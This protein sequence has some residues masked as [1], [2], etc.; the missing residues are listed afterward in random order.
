MHVSATTEF[1][2]ILTAPSD[3]SRINRSANRVNCFSWNL[4]CMQRKVKRLFRKINFVSFRK[5][6]R[7]HIL[8]RKARLWNANGTAKSLL[9]LSSFTRME[10]FSKSHV[11]LDSREVAPTESKSRMSSTFHTSFRNELVGSLACCMNTRVFDE[12]DQKSDPREKDSEPEVLL[13]STWAQRIQMQKN[14]K[15]QRSGVL[16]AVVHRRTERKMTRSISFRGKALLRKLLKL[17][18]SS[19]PRKKT[20][21]KGHK[22]E[23]LQSNSPPKPVK[24]RPESP[25]RMTMTSEGDS[26]AS[27]SCCHQ[28]PLQSMSSMVKPVSERNS[29]SGSRVQSQSPSPSEVQQQICIE[30]ATM[31]TDGVFSHETMSEQ[32]I[33][34][35]IPTASLIQHSSDSYIRESQF[36][37]NLECP[38]SE[39]K[40]KSKCVNGNVEDSE[41]RLTAQSLKKTKASNQ[42]P[43]SKRKNPIMRCL[44]RKPQSPMLLKQGNGKS[45]KQKKPIANSPEKVFSLG[46]Q[47]AQVSQHTSEAN[48]TLRTASLDSHVKPF[49]LLFGSLLGHS[50]F[51]SNWLSLMYESE[52]C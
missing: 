22:K 36:D 24:Q 48:R 12:C 4:V 46:F 34:Q 17:G 27:Q 20:R 23:K 37:V 9:T 3:K 25:S 8:V 13:C 45:P 49:D 7:V 10:L 33:H 39:P 16:I 42:S 2:F 47:Q 52:E 29:M 5:G 15:N 51:T 21:A 31:P 44:R 28:Q 14:R 26:F 19:L 32:G 41:K 50:K 38:R 11:A 1:P 40:S 43:S 18:R 6:R 30:K 35:N